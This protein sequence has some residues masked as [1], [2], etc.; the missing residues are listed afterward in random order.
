MK[1]EW[2]FDQQIYKELNF[3]RATVVRDLVPKLR[4]VMPLATAVDVGCGVGYFSEVLHS[5]GLNVMGLDA[6]EQNVME[7]RRRYPHLRF[8]T[9]NAEDPRLHEF[10]QFDLVFCFGLLYHL[11]NPFQ[12]IRNLSA[13]A[14]HIALLEGVCYP[15]KES[16][17]ALID[18]DD[19]NDQGVKNIAFYPSEACLLKMLYSSGFSSCFLPRIMP[20]H[21]FYNPTADSLRYRTLLA[22]SKH[23][24]Q[25]DSLILQ[26]VPVSSLRA[27][28]LVPMRTVGA[29]ASKLLDFIQLITNPKRAATKTKDAA[30]VNGEK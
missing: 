3:A 14:A 4:A 16:M 10:G 17:M 5:L 7:A 11:E 9:M 25:L 20:S 30:S 6:R 21:P 27:W 22:A 13:M 1:T 26:P 18:E 29:R 19:L 28:H 2:A 23:P 15:S 24:V 8:E 12:A